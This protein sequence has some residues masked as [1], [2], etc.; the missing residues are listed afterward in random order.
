M[1]QAKLFR[2]YMYVLD[3]HIQMQVDISFTTFH[4]DF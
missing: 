2:L 4:I 3:I 1:Y